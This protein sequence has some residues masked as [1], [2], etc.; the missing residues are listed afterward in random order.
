[1]KLSR[2]NLWN[3]T[4]GT[5]NYL[6]GRKA[7]MEYRESVQENNFSVERGRMDIPPSKTVL[8]FS[9]LGRAVL[10]S[11]IALG[12]AAFKGLLPDIGVL[13]NPGFYIG[14]NV[15]NIPNTLLYDFISHETYKIHHGNE[16][17]EIRND[18][19]MT[20]LHA[21]VEE[22][23]KINA[24]GPETD[25]DSLSLEIMVNRDRFN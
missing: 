12:A 10:G 16:A 20:R 22:M 13:D 19:Q 9:L 23:A 11:S 21:A 18:E 8:A 4:K 3:K 15:I 24:W 1:M 25:L 5:V 17:K 14:L 6:S 7:Y 2:E